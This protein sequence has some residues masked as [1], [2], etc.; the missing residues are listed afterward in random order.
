MKATVDD[1]RRKLATVRTGR[2]SLAILDGITRRLL[3]DRRRR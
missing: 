3:R 2:A 1:F